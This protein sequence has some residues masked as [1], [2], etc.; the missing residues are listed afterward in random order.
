MRYTRYLEPKDIL[1]AKHA[2]KRGQSIHCKGIS[3]MQLFAARFHERH[4]DIPEARAAYGLVLGNLAP[5]LISAVLAHANL[6]RRQVNHHVLHLECHPAMI[7]HS[8]QYEVLVCPCKC[9]H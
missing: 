6:E 8:Y 9:Y 7:L 1:A 4:G 3:E 5:G 2:V